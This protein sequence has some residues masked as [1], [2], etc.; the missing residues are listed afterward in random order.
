MSVK[1]ILLLMVIFMLSIIFQAAMSG[2]ALPRQ[3]E[4]DINTLSSYQAVAER[5][6]FGGIFG[7]AL[8]APEYLGAMFRIATQPVALLENP[9]LN[10]VKMLLYFPLIVTFVGGLVLIISLAALRR[11]F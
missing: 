5:Q 9:D 6:L 10:W 1:W 2:G 8:A 3:T 7:Y 4:R 11:Q